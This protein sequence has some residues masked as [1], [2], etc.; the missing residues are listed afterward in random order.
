MA[1][2]TPFLPESAP[3]E[4][5]GGAGALISKTVLLLMGDAAAAEGVATL[6]ASAIRF[7]QSSVNGVEEIANSMRASGWVGS[8]V[9][10]V[11]M[12]G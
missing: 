2:G 9:D 5:L 3:E 8:P 1:V 11:S 4:I 6:D 10:V 7:S 12:E